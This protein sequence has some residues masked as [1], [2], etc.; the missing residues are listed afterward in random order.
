MKR[1]FE[2]EFRALKQSEIPDL[3]NRI[4]AGL[5]EKKNTTHMSQNIKETDRETSRKQFAWRRWGTLI[6]ACLCV[7]I[8]LP[9]FTL[10]VRNKSYS[11]GDTT[12]ESAAE[13]IAMD[14]SASESA[15]SEDAAAAEETVFDEPADEPD[16]YDGKAEGNLSDGTDAGMADSSETGAGAENGAAGTGSVEA[17]TS[18]DTAPAEEAASADTAPAAE[19][20]ASAEKED[21]QVKES[22]TADE[23]KERWKELP[24]GQ[25][26]EDV[27]IEIQES[28]DG[29][30]L[31]Q[32]WVVQ[33]DADGLLESRTQITVMCDADT[34]YD[35]PAG[36]R[37]EKTLTEDMA[38]QVDL[39]YDGKEEKFVVVTAE[40]TEGAFY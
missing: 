36:P 1:D 10:L 14:N 15:V 8:I 34:V 32:A 23:A 28:G 20:A 7:V 37:E 29:G 12:M 18:A 24:D 40:N 5:S 13:N 9:A 11:G 31:Y 17:A 21:A 27:I 2:Q 19:E 30:M 38:Y 4:E 35:F 3:W 39:R 25:M 6:A 22:A 26:L 16:D 33:A